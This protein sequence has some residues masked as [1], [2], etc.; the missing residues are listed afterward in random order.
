MR[1]SASRLPL[2]RIGFLTAAAALTS[3]NGNASVNASANLV[4]GAY[5]VSATVSGAAAPAVFSLTND[6]GSPASVVASSSATGQ[7]A[8]VGTQFVNALSVTVLDSYGN[9]VPGVTVTFASPTSARGRVRLP[10][11]CQM[12]RARRA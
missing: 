10:R 6:P 2:G 7:T 9:P 3:V 8:A 4:A 5:A 11:P 1:P 12:D